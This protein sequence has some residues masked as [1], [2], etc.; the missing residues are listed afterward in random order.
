MRLEIGVTVERGS[1]V[2]NGKNRK[3]SLVRDRFQFPNKLTDTGLIHRHGVNIDAQH[4]LH[5]AQPGH[6]VVNRSLRQRF[7]ASFTGMVGSQIDCK[8]VAFHHHRLVSKSARLVLA[9]RSAKLAIGLA[10]V[11]TLLASPT[12]ADSGSRSIVASV[13]DGDT[14]RLTTGERI[15]IAGIDAP[16]TQQDQA[17]CALERERGRAASRQLRAMLEGQSVTIERASRSYNR[18][19]ARVHFNGR[20]LGRELI[21]L[22]IARPWPRGTPK[23]DWCSWNV[24]GTFSLT[25]T[26]HPARPDAGRTHVLV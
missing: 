20:D 21:R 12:L 10:G 22:G 11:L 16:E 15:R 5:P 4:L 2:S 17:R 8:G 24:S 19:V 25:G 14:F 7:A 26:R 13:T 6:A 9:L 1:A 23:P 18:T 3:A